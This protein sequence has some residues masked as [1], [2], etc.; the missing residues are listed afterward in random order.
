[1]SRP[2]KQSTHLQPAQRCR[3][4]TDVGRGDAAQSEF[5]RPGH[6]ACSA[7]CRLDLRSPLPVSG[8]KSTSSPPRRAVVSD[9]FRRRVLGSEEKAAAKFWAHLVA[10]VSESELRPALDPDCRSHRRYLCR[11]TSRQVISETTLS[12]LTA[13]TFLSSFSRVVFSLSLSQLSLSYLSSPPN[14]TRAAR[15]RL[16]PPRLASAVCAVCICLCV[17][18][19]LQGDDQG[20]GSW[21]WL[22]L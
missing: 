20:C 7:R 2:R 17:C 12:R 9:Y 15:T 6:N 10:W 1:M 8:G 19:L 11:S 22:K 4:L 16:L 13:W 14:R 5:G 3:A 21:I 18:V